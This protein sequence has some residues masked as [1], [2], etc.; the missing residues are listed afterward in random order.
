MNQSLFGHGEVPVYWENKILGIWEP[1]FIDSVYDT[2]Y[3]DLL[4]RKNLASSVSGFLWGDL[5]W[6]KYGWP[7][8]LAASY[9]GGSTLTIKDKQYDALTRS[10]P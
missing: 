6:F 2:A 9:T 5:K 4:A 3:R 10:Y 1:T 8:P 7:I